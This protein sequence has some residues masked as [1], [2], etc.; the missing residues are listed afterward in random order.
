MF[1]EN[2]AIFPASFSN[3]EIK[4]HTMILVD[5]LWYLNGHF[6]KIQDKAVHMPSIVPI[7]K[8]YM[9]KK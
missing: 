1:E 2:R 7:P 9:Y 8:R 5:A 4:R 3:E 6:D